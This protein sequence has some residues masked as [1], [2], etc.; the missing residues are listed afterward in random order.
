MAKTLKKKVKKTEPKAEKVSTVDA[1]AKKPVEEPKEEVKEEVEEPVKE[2][3]PEPVLKKTEPVEEKPVPSE[4]L[5]VAL[6]SK[7]AMDMV[8][9]TAL[10]TTVKFCQGKWWKL[11]VDKKVTGTQSQIAYLRA[12]GFVK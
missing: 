8:T 10:K 12:Q 2:E 1:V 11:V 4:D 9:T 3:V 6:P 5:P 7:V